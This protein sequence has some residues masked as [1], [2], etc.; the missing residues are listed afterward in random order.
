[1]LAMQVLGKRYCRGFVAHRTI[2]EF[3]L[4]Y[5]IETIGTDAFVEHLNDRQQ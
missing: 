2:H 3:G 4:S 5:R 1:M